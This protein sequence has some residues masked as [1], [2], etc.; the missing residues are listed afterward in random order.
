MTTCRGGVNSTVMAVQHHEAL[1]L[2]SR[3]FGVSLMAAKYS[4]YVDT[5][6]DT[7]DFMSCN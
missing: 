1:R 4:R 7:L 6:T 2:S 5:V 3:T